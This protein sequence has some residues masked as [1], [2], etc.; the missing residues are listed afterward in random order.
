MVTAKA[1]FIS[2]RLREKYGVVGKVAERYIS[3][4]YSV[5]FNVKC[6]DVLFDFIAKKGEKI[7][8]KIYNGKIKV[9]LEDIEK[10]SRAAE[11]LGVKPVIVLYGSGPSVSEEALDKADE[12]NISIKRIRP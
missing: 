5:T 10:I 8:V 4:G 2:R 9:G 3:A 11:K 12:L 6:N 7:G 1:K